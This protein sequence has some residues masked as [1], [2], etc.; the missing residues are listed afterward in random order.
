MGLFMFANVVVMMLSSL[1]EGF[2]CEIPAWKWKYI[3]SNDENQIYETQRHSNS[4]VLIISPSS[5]SAFHHE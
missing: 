3:F 2:N 4:G 5:P 1:L